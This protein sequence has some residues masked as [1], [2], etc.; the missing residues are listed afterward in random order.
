[1]FHKDCHPEDSDVILNSNL[2]KNEKVKW[3]LHFDETE[4]RYKF[5]KR[6][7]L[8]TQHEILQTINVYSIA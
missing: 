4:G 5:N 1:M 8:L 6:N 7:N 2:V 3:E